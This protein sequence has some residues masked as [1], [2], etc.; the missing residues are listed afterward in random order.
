MIDVI[1]LLIFFGLFIIICE[2]I[3]LTLLKTINIKHN[4]IALPIGMALFGCLYE[5]LVLPVQYFNLDSSLLKYAVIASLLIALIYV[6]KEIVSIAKFLSKRD[7][8]IFIIFTVLFIIEAL[9][10]TIYGID[11]QCSDNMFYIPFVNG[12]SVDGVAVNGLMSNM[13]TNMS[14]TPTYAFYGQLHFYVGISNLLNVDGLITINFFQRWY[15]LIF[16]ITNIYNICKICQEYGLLKN[17]N[18]YLVILFIGVSYLSVLTNHE[19]MIVSTTTMLFVIAPLLF[20]LKDNNKGWLVLFVIF[21]YHAIS[22]RSTFIFL[23]AF[24][25]LPYYLYLL[26]TNRFEIKEN[27]YIIIPTLFSLILYIFYGKG[28]VNTLL[29][30]LVLLAIIVFLPT[31]VNK[32]GVKYTKYLYIFVLLGIFGYFVINSL[33]L[34]NVSATWDNVLVFDQ[35]NN[36]FVDF[37]SFSNVIRSLYNIS[38]FLFGVILLIYSI[39]KKKTVSYYVMHDVIIFVLCLNWL[40]APFLAKMLIQVY[41][42]LFWMWDNPLLYLLILD[43]LIDIIQNINIKKIVNIS[44]SFVLILGFSIWYIY[45]YANRAKNVIS[46]FKEN[47]NNISIYYKVGKD[48]YEIGKVID[49][50]AVDNN[51][52]FVYT[53]CP[54]N[55][56]NSS[57]VSNKI[58]LSTAMGNYGTIQRFMSFDIFKEQ[59]NESHYEYPMFFY[60]L[61]PYRFFD[62]WHI[63]NDQDNIPNIEKLLK[64]SNTNIF[65]INK[66]KDKEET[67]YLFKDYFNKFSNLLYENDNYLVYVVK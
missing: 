48:S 24:F 61:E 50:Y 19:V 33:L 27:V 39:C 35:L 64:D 63:Q 41:E 25:L 1:K 5:V 49:Q 36:Y 21:S 34:G 51:L 3:G 2:A 65:V 8:F 30:L 58:R 20:Y 10:L 16:Y 22:I 12:I 60:L 44:L 42:R 40:V 57:Y 37:A 17:I 26:F 18:K 32:I 4:I 53:V 62:D 54:T 38:F 15:L 14:V 45:S 43:E 55:L 59:Y 66:W 13:Y 47:K 67:D 52:K 6:R 56:I 11:T 28:I 46:S 7:I 9:D 23:L 29:F 31:I